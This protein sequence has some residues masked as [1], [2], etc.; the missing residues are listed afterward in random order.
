MI[1]QFLMFNYLKVKVQH[2][3]QKLLVEKKT[4]QLTSELI[5][6]CRNLFR[7]NLTY[8]FLCLHSLKS[9]IKEDLDEDGRED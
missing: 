2:I 8:F 7:I 4:N 9:A 6:C 3:Q 1:L 5:Y